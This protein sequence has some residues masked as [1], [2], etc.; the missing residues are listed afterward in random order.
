MSNTEYAALLEGDA[1]VNRAG[2]IQAL[3][4]RGV[5]VVASD[6]NPQDLVPGN[7]NHIAFQG[8]LFW[9]D[10]ADATTPHD[11]ISVIVTDDGK[12][13]KADGVHGTRLRFWKVKDKDLTAPPVSP[14]AGD[15]YIVGAG[16][17]GAWAAKDK[18]IATYTERGWF[19]EIPGSYD[20]AMVVDETLF[21]HY[22][23]GGAWTSG[24]PAL[25]I[26]ANTV[27]PGAIRYARF[28]LGVVNQTT[29][30]PPGSPADGDSYIIGGSPT[31]AWSGKARQI[32]IYEVSAWAYYVPVEGDHA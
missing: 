16:A 8:L 13:F 24:L 22:S 21:Y 12:R 11:G 1:P 17:S 2:L 31:G 32:A 28:G 3:E 26:G 29:N 4:K 15:S 19:F 23:A 18:Y 7:V 9:Y 20:V 25:T 6:E 5:Y 27:Y 10:A 30:A 14:V